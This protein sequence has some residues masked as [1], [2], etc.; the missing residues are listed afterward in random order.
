MTVRCSVV[1]WCRS[2]NS[3]Y[4]DTKPSVNRGGDATLQY[5]VITPPSAAD[6]AAFYKARDLSQYAREPIPSQEFR[7]VA[8]RSHA[9]S[10]QD[11]SEWVPE[12]SGLPQLTSASMLMPLV[13]ALP[14]P[15]MR[16]PPKPIRRL[17]PAVVRHFNLQ[18]VVGAPPPATA[19]DGGPLPAQASA[20]MA[21]QEAASSSLSGRSSADGSQKPASK[22]DAISQLATSL[23]EARPK[24][25][26]RATRPI[27][28]PTPRRPPLLGTPGEPP[29]RPAPACLSGR[30]KQSVVGI[31]A[32]HEAVS[33]RQAADRG[34]GPDR[35]NGSA[36]PC[37]WPHRCRPARPLHATR[38]CAAG[39][40]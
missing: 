23:S 24:V 8:G 37:Q 17:D 6:M 13:D 29:Y 15:D 5:L 28:A 32:K 22:A 18:A 7:A 4:Q 39:L 2:Y 33:S 38:R 9:S 34:G 14:P 25:S 11:V 26:G 21:S 20:A 19:I 3:A 16:L 12:L 10:A 31:P 36:A 40:R 35:A 30:A 27:L 1:V